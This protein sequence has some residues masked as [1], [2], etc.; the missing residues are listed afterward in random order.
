MEKHRI[1]VCT[2]GRCRRKGAYDLLKALSCELRIKAGN[3][4]EDSL[5]S[6]ET[7]PCT[8][9]C[10]VA[11]VITVDGKVYDRVD[12]KKARQILTKYRM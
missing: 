4:A 1:A 3:A 6:L 11:P 10:G 7:V 5:F 9:C 2:G 12:M 8:G